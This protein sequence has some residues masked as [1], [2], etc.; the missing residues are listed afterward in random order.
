MVEPE[1][2]LAA[3]NCPH[4][5]AY[6]QMYWQ[7]VSLYSN[8]EHEPDVNISTCH[9]CDK[10]ALWDYANGWKMVYPQKV[11][12]PLPHPDMPEALKKDFEEARQVAPISPR[13]ACALLRLVIQKLLIELGEKGKNIDNDIQ[14][15]VDKGLSPR[16]QRA[17]DVVRVTGNNAVHPGELDEKDIQTVSSSLFGLVN[18]IIDSAIST[19]KKLNAMYENLPKGALEGIA[20]R[21]SKSERA[22]K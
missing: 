3:F 7:R 19:D 10:L 15:L 11:L 13:A 9:V 22:K 12:S 6:A 5:G 2:N 20:N 8:S 18:L 14:S 16:I 17:L 1:F 21:E 4:C